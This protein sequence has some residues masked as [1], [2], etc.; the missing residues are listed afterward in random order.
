MNSKVLF[1]K[2]FII[3]MKEEMNE[4]IIDWKVNLVFFFFLNKLSLSSREVT[5][6]NYSLKPILNRFNMRVNGGGIKIF[7][8]LYTCK[9][10]RYAS[11]YTG[12]ENY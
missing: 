4:Y 3:K 9:T 1:F 11:M 6:W 8:K 12:V 10:L 5:K 7:K 2:N